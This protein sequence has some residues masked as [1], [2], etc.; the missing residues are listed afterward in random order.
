MEYGG[1]KKSN[2]KTRKYLIKKSKTKT[3]KYLIKKS[4]TKTRK[5]RK[6]S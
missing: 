1:K 4:K 6:R 3:R 2:T 5:T